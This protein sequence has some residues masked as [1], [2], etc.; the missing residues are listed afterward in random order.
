MIYRNYAILNLVSVSSV[1]ELPDDV[2]HQQNVA[3]CSEI[4]IAIYLSYRS[5]SFVNA[6]DSRNVIVVKWRH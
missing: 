2:T 4:I 1:K 6:I 5:R 3:F